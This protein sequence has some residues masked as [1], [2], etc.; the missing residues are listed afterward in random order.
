MITSITEN[1]SYNEGSVIDINIHFREPVVVSG[2]PYLKLSTGQ[3]SAYAF[4][5]SG[6]ES[7]VLVFRYQVGS[8]ENSSNLNYIDQNS[9]RINDGMLKDL[10]GNQGEL[11]L[12]DPLGNNSLSS[13]SNIIIDTDSPKTFFAFNEKYFNK[14]GWSEIGQIFGT[15][16]DSLSG[17]SIVKIKIKRESDEFFLSGDNWSSESIWLTAQGAEQWVFDLD[18]QLLSSGVEYTIFCKSLDIAG[19]VE[20]LVVKDSFIYDTELPSS[21]IQMISHIYS[22]L[23]WEDDD[24]GKV[25][26]FKHKDS[27]EK[28]ISLKRL[29]IYKIL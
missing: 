9:F 2:G 13:N 21:D 22:D 4:Y 12:P 19:N 28:P 24:Y 26:F 20:T 17:V 29:K 16:S 5:E 8:G 18:P 14:D 1:G 7:S 23:N 3:D 15:S 6:T 11:L 27:S 10:A 25:V